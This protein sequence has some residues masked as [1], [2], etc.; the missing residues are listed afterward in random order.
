MKLQVQVRKGGGSRYWWFTVLPAPPGVSRIFPPQGTSCGPGASS[1]SKGVA[2]VAV[3]ERGGRD[4]YA[5]QRLY[6][7]LAQW[8]PARGS[9]PWRRQ[10]AVTAQLDELYPRRRVARHSIQSRRIEIR[11]RI[12]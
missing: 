8:R 1:T 6:A 2:G 11:E 10:T 4:R 9:E 12:A 3:H 5:T 7:L